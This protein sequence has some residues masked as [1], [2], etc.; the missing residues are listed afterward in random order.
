MKI[1]VI[2]LLSVWCLYLLVFYVWPLIFALS[3]RCLSER[4]LEA[5]LIKCYRKFQNSPRNVNDKSL[6]Q[7]LN[8]AIH[9]YEFWNELK[10]SIQES[11][12]QETNAQE[13]ANL[14]NDII[15]C[16]QK[17]DFWGGALETLQKEIQRREYFNSF[18]N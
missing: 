3:L 5:Y 18:R 14:Q 7:L 13:K 4:N 17:I 2:I 9:S 6:A 15:Y 12:A 16:D 11:L 1:F 10:S 8:L